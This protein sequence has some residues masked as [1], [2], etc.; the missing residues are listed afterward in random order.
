MPIELLYLVMA[1]S[2][3]YDAA[4]RWVVAAFTSR[5]EAFNYREKA[6][7]ASAALIAEHKNRPENKGQNYVYITEPTAY[8]LGHS[9]MDTDV[10][11]WVEPVPMPK[12]LLPKGGL[13]SIADSFSDAAAVCRDLSYPEFA[14]ARGQKRAPSEPVTGD[15]AA[16]LQAALGH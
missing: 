4:T 1:T 8:D 13:M 3:M 15:F 11:Y 14:K 6:A 16:K 2:G 5:D 12:G 9:V 7:E 10:R